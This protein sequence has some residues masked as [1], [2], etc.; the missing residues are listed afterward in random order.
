MLYAWLFQV[1]D[2][3]PHTHP[4]NANPPI[5]TRILTH[6]CT[7]TPL[8]Q[9]VKSHA[10]A[11]YY[12]SNVVEQ[13]RPG[14]CRQPSA[15]YGMPETPR[16]DTFEKKDKKEKSCLVSGRLWVQFPLPPAHDHVPLGKFP[17]DLCLQERLLYEILV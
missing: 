3:H 4:L 13:N 15:L 12:N 1:T 9:M 16:Q 2:S 6:P 17:A 10:N 14:A 11:G 8:R 7:N 5:S